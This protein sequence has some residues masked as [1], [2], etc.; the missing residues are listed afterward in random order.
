MK[1]RTRRATAGAG[2]PPQ[3]S[4]TG[5]ATY[6]ICPKQYYYTQIVPLRPPYQLALDRGT[7]IHSILEDVLRGK[8]IPG[9][10]QLDDWA[11]PYLANFLVSRFSLS[12]P[13]H[14]E[15]SFR[16]ELPGGLIRGRIDTVYERNDGGA[17]SWE[18]V[19]FK[20]GRPER[21]DVCRAKLQGKLYALAARELWKVPSITWSY[22]YLADGSIHSFELDAGAAVDAAARVARALEGITAGRWEPSRGC[23]CWVCRKTPQELARAEDYW[24]RRRAHDLAGTVESPR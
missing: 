10:D 3:V 11:K 21:Y 16:L 18:I 20:S 13:L 22:F 9:L 8:S 4:V 23:S 17:K 14:I 15:K 7:N 24:S 1:R 6:E 5:L 12:T 2:D 19:D